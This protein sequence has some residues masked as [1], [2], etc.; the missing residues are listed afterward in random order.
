MLRHLKT[1]LALLFVMALA[2][3]GWAFSLW[4]ATETWQTTAL[5]YLT[6]YFYSPVPSPYNQPPVTPGNVPY[7]ELGGPKNIQQGSR[8]N[9]AVITYGFDYTFLDYFG[10][11]GVKAVDAAFAILN[12]LPSASSATPDL[13]E[14]IT[15]G[16]QQ[17][18]YTARALCMLDM[19]SVVLQLMIEHMGLLGETHVF[20]LLGQGGSCGAAYYQVGVRNFDPITWNPTTYVNGTDY[21]YII[22]DACTVGTAIADALEEANSEPGGGLSPN[23]SAVATQEA[24]QLGGFYL[25]ITR[26]DFGGLRYLYRKNNYNIESLPTGCFVGNPTSVSPWAPITT[27]TNAAS[28]TILSSPWTPYTTNTNTLSIFTNTFTNGILGGVEKITF[29]KVQADSLIGYTWPTNMSSFS[30]PIL[31]NYSVHQLPVLRSNIGPDILFTAANLLNTPAAGE[32]QPYTRVVSFLASP[33]TPP[34]TTATVSGVILPTNL[35]TFN[36]IGPIYVNE[37]PGFLQGSAF[38]LYPYF[39]F[40]SFDGSTNPPIAFPNRASL[41]GLLALELTA[42]GPSSFANSPWNPIINTNTLAAT[43]TAAGTVATGTGTTGTGT[44]GTGAGAGTGT[45]GGTG[46]GAAAAERLGGGNP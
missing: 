3:Q 18:N 10:V 36:D 11:D 44:T 12:H 38:F 13:T 41:A 28:G 31:S 40:G 37:N 1:F 32:D 46:G 2:P 20:D 24:L 15:D 9:V 23:T 26:D 42:P 33:V 21:G 45:G 8:L 35:V 29:V 7:T 17:I 16:N 25:G 19:K 14:F 34:N 4:G 6:R 39:Q 27:N 22:A 30:I 5:S 43:G